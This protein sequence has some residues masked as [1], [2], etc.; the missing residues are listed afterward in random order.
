MG[1]NNSALEGT[2][3]LSRIESEFA[4]V[5]HALTEVMQGGDS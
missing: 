3:L 4:I 5:S 2:G 1:K